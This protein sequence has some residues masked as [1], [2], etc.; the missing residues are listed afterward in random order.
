MKHDPFVKSS[1][2]TEC[3]VEVREFSSIMP[4]VRRWL[5]SNP[6]LTSVVIISNPECAYYFHFLITGRPMIVYNILIAYDYDPD[7]PPPNFLWKT[8]LEGLFVVL[9]LMVF[10]LFL[11]FCLFF[12]MQ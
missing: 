11:N 3:D 9:C 12:Q 5:F 2:C 6:A 7:F 4:E 1:N 10:F 8:L